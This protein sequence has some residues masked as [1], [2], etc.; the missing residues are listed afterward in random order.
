MPAAVIFDLDG[1]LIDSE[2]IWRAVEQRVFAPLGVDL[3]DDD[4]RGTM[5][6]RVDE[7]VA[8]WF[9]RRPWAGPDPAEVVRRIVDGV[10]EVIGTRGTPMPGVGHAIRVAHTPDTRLA[11]A[12]SSPERVIHAALRRLG[13]DATFEVVV[14]AQHEPRGKPDPGVFLTTARVLGVSPAA[15]TA[16][17]DSPNG[18]RA[19]K[20]AGMWCVAVPEPGSHTTAVAEAGADVVLGSLADLAAEHLGPRAGPDQRSS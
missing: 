9:A 20:A 8:H 2:P 17:E 18:V 12:S 1:L 7:V 14:S 11:L 3:T 5:G 4:C 13:H 15:C 6:L 19:A 16:I 10:V